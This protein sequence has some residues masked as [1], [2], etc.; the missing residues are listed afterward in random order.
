MVVADEKADVYI[1]IDGATM[2]NVN[3]DRQWKRLQEHW[4]HYDKH[5]QL[6][7]RDQNNNRKGQ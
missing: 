7:K 4:D 2:G 6:L 1:E 5:G 3:H